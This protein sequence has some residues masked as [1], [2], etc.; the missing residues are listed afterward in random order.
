LLASIYL[1]EYASSRIKRFFSP[2][3][4][5]LAGIPPVIYGVWGTLT[6]VPLIAD[7]IAPLVVDYSTGYSMLAGGLVLLS[8]SSRKYSMQFQRISVKHHGRWAQQNGKPLKR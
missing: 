4:D 8:V 5:L 2:V 7:K 3:V 6:I 1:S